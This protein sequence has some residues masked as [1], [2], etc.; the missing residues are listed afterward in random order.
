MKRP[1]ATVLLDTTDYAPQRPD[2]EETFFWIAQEAL[3]NVVKHAHAQRALIE[4][5]ADEGQVC[6]S[7]TD[8][9]AGFARTLAG[10]GAFGLQ[11][12]H[13]RAAAL[14]GAVQIRSAPGCGTTVTACLPRKDASP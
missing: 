3:H 1:P 14:G 13:E 8:D 5:R 12:M 2:H 11:I 4:L 7:V 10:S 9:G 6:L